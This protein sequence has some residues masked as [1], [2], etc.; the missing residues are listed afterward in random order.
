ME[1]NSNVY[2]NIIIESRKKLNISGVKDVT[3]FDDETILLDT[4]LGK[5]TVKGEN[6]HIENF[7]TETGDLMATGQIHAVVYM[8]DG[9]SSGGFISRIFR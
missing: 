1:E 2:Q 4:K 7:N 3:S 8:S 6:L 9:K 5:M